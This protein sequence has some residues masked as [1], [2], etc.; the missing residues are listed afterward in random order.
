MFHKDY[1]RAPVESPRAP[2]AHTPLP[3]PCPQCQH[4]VLPAEEFPVEVWE[5]FSDGDLEQLVGDACLEIARRDR[6]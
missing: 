3:T 2:L 5:F 6:A 1:R 4:A